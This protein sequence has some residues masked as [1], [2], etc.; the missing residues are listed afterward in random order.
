ML[1]AVLPYS[2]SFPSMA[3]RKQQHISSHGSHSKGSCMPS[4]APSKSLL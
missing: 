3:Q 2:D 4:D 1:P